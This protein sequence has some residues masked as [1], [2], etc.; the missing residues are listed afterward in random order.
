MKKARRISKNHDRR[1]TS[2]ERRLIPPLFPYL[3]SLPAV[4]TPISMLSFLKR[5]SFEAAALFAV[6]RKWGGSTISTIY[7]KKS[8]LEHFFGAL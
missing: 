7:G 8:Q 6:V 3:P 2:S 5:F 4:E 1:T